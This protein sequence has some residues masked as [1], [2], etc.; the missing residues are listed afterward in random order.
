MSSDELA[1][2]ELRST[3]D[4]AGGDRAGVAPVLGSETDLHLTSLVHLPRPP[5][6]PLVQAG[7]AV[8]TVLH[9]AGRAAPARHLLHQPGGLELGHQ[10]LAAGL[11]VV[12]HLHHLGV[13]A[14]PGDA[15]LVELPG[16]AVLPLVVAPL[17]L[18]TVRLLAGRAFKTWHRLRHELLHHWSLGLTLPLQ[19]YRLRGSLVDP[20]APGYFSVVSQS[21]LPVVQ[22]VSSLPVQTEVVG[23]ATVLLTDFTD[24]STPHPIGWRSSSPPLSSL[25]FWSL[26][27][28]LFRIL[29]FGFF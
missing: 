28:C 5:E 18:H 27:L 22:P 21:L 24:V 19:C 25:L 9:D 20:R 4:V 16:A 15:P 7:P 12:L 8:A 26:L 6:L 2:D 3:S 13:G 1:G 23:V 10:P 17:A 11:E 29:P 14:A